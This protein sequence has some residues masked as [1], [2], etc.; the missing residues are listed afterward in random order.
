MICLCWLIAL[1]LIC[2]TIFAVVLVRT[3]GKK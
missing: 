3:F 1:F 2:C